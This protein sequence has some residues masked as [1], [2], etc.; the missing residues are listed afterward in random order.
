MFA[1]TAPGELVTKNGNAMRNVV[2]VGGLATTVVCAET[3]VPQPEVAIN[4]YVVVVCGCA[5]SIEP[6]GPNVPTLA[7]VTLIPVPELST[8]FQERRTT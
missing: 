8:T 2:A 1:K 3:C 6:L 7:M 5:I 4:V